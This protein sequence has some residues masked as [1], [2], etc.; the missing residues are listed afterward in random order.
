MSAKVKGYT[1]EQQQAGVAVFLDKDKM[2]YI[3]T[4]KRVLNQTRNQLNELRECVKDGVN[5]FVAGAKFDELTSEIPEKR[6]EVLETYGMVRIE[7][8][9]G[10]KVVSRIEFAPKNGDPSC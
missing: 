6:G 3:A 7:E 2:K 10:D 9:V 4:L 1:T 5:A 8:M